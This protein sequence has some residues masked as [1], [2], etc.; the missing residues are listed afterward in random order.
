MDFFSNLV[1]N[2]A[3]KVETLTKSA[4]AAANSAVSSLSP[5]GANSPTEEAQNG[6]QQQP[7]EATAENGAI[8][9]DLN[10]K[11]L[12]FYVLCT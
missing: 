1:K 12:H 4:T 5:T 8:I 10:G 3:T 2:T 6:D 11:C 7:V 9:N